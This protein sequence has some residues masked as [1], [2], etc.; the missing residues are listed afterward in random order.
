[1]DFFI[2]ILKKVIIL[3]F[4]FLVPN[5]PFYYVGAKLSWC[6]IDRFY[7]L[8]AKLTGAKLSR[9]Q[10]V[11]CQIVLPPLRAIRCPRRMS[12]FFLDQKISSTSCVPMALAGCPSSVRLWL[13]RRKASMDLPPG[14]DPETGPEAF[15]PSSGVEFFVA[16]FEYLRVVLQQAVVDPEENKKGKNKMVGSSCNYGG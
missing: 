12:S 10:I 8:G 2:N 4:F 11:R 3:C 6:Q 16:Y 5:F 1:M 13:L 7:Y 9:C 15:L 14:G